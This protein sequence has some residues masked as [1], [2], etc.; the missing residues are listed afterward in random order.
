MVKI[1]RF[2][3]MSP[4]RTMSLSTAKIDAF[5]LKAKNDHEAILEKLMN[6]PF[7]CPVDGYVG[8]FLSS[9]SLK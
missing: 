5:V 9:Y 8:E 4:Y 6:Q 3:F 7:K 2:E 1:D